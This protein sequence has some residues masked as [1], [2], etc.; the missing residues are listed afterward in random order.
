MKNHESENFFLTGCAFSI[1]AL[2]LLCLSS[3]HFSQSGQAFF[4]IQ[5]FGHKT[6][7]IF[8]LWSIQ[9]FFSGIILGSLLISLHFIKKPNIV[10]VALIAT[11]FAF[12]WEIVELG[13]VSGC[14]GHQVSKWFVDYGRIE[15][16]IR[17]TKTS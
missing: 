16:V 15:G 11:L 6:K 9:H 13:A 5:L 3:F 8:D 2:Q 1:I 12:G 17:I 4:P 14:F 10:E 7:A